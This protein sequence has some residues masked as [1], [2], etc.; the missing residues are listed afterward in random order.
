[1]TLKIGKEPMK[2][3]N[4]SNSITIENTNG[5]NKYKDENI[6]TS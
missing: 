1:M 2:L 5:N 4:Q 3:R 6:Q